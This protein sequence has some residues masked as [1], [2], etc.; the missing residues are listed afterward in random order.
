MVGL[1]RVA[2]GDGQPTPSLPCW[3]L[4]VP[5]QE[6]KGSWNPAEVG[7]S[8]EEEADDAGEEDKATSPASFRGCSGRM[9]SWK[10]DRRFTLLL[11]AWGGARARARACA[12][13]ALN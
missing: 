7:V 12:T 8:V 3:T 4:G 11:L 2:T 6:P 10:R 1:L 5:G 9:E 13:F